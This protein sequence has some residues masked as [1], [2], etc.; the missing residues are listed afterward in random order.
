MRSGGRGLAFE[1]R[2]RRASFAALGRGDRG[3]DDMVE[4]GCGKECYIQLYEYYMSND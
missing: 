4:A 2:R 3:R 1:L